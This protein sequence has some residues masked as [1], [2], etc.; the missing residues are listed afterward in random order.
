MVRRTRAH[1]SASFGSK[2]THWVPRRIVSS[3]KMNNRRTL[4]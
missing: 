3:M 4:M 1:S 2:T